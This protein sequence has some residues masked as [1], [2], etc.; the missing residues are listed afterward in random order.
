MWKTIIA[1]ALTLACL[2]AARAEKSVVWLVRDT[3]PAFIYGGALAGQGG[4]DLDLI[5][6]EKHLTDY[7]HMVRH[8]S[9]SRLW[10]ELEKSPASCTL[11]VERPDSDQP[12]VVFSKRPVM[13]PG[14]R[15]VVKRE[16]SQLF[17][18]FMT[19]DRKIDLKL[20]GRQTRLS[21]VYIRERPYPRAIADLVKDPLRD[22]R[23]EVIPVEGLILG[24]LESDRVDFTFL[25]GSELIYLTDVASSTSDYVGLA[26]E[27]IPGRMPLVAA[28]SR[29]ATGLAIIARIDELLTSDSAWTAFLDP[30]RRWV[31]P[32]DRADWP[33]SPAPAAAGPH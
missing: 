13:I 4:F 5:F 17:E 10:H 3:P 29:D 20:L 12:N 19:P 32:A 8:V 11:A 23:L 14:M 1:A 22:A 16:K 30:L 25:S 21:G 31:L 7:A 24:L 15:L 6:L 26:I 2:Q 9:A 27:D 33:A 18:A 28:C